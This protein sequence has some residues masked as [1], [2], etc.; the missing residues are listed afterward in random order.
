MMELFRQ[1]GIGYDY[2]DIQSLPNDERISIK[3]AAKEMGLK[4]FPIIKLPNGQLTKNEDLIRQF[5]E[6]TDANYKK[7]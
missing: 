1:K 7:R 4:M 5:E 2:I 3:K 6:G